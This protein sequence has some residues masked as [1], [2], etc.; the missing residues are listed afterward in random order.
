M[1]GWMGLDTNTSQVDD[2]HSHHKKIPVTAGPFHGFWWPRDARSQGIISHTTDLAR[3]E[4]CGLN[5]TFAASLGY[6]LKPL[7]AK[8][9]LILMYS[10]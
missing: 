2:I 6:D 8:V 5:N 10:Q 4:Y 1:D 7:S 3:P 9:G